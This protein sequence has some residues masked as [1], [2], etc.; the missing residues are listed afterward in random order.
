M[1]QRDAPEEHND[2]HE[3]RHEGYDNNQVDAGFG[4]LLLQFHLLLLGLEL[5]G[6]LK[7]FLLALALHET[8]GDHIMALEHLVGLLITAGIADA[9]GIEIQQGYVIVGD[10]VLF[11]AVEGLEFVSAGYERH[12]PRRRNSS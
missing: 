2:G 11:F 5:L 9:L 6:I 1:G 3:E 8:I 4:L 7:G 10:G 12:R